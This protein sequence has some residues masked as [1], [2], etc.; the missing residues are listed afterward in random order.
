[1]QQKQLYNVY[2]QQS[3][4]IEEFFSINSVFVNMAD[5]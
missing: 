5:N 1:M 2:V 4:S 3:K